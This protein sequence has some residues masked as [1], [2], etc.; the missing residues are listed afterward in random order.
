MAEEREYPLAWRHDCQ[1]KQD[2][3]G[4]VVEVSTRYWPPNYDSAGR[5]TA[6]SSILLGGVAV[7]DEQFAAADVG[8][9]KRL[10]EQW[11]SAQIKAVEAAILAMVNPGPPSAGEQAFRQA[12]ADYPAR[13]PQLLQARKVCSGVVAMAESLLERRAD[14]FAAAAMKAT[15]GAPPAPPGFIPSEC[16]CTITLVGPGQGTRG[17]TCPY[18][19]SFGLQRTDET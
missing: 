9:C 17:P 5:H 18:C 16:R 8:A 11:V 19:R 4:R 14:E 2:Y 13:N 15:G 1:G 10:V 7:V 12:L 6:H 3:D